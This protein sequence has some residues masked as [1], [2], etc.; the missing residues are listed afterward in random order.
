[1]KCS[2][3]AAFLLTADDGTLLYSVIPSQGCFVLYGHALHLAGELRWQLKMA[4]KHN[5]SRALILFVLLTHA[6][7]S[8]NTDP[9]CTTMRMTAQCTAVAK[10]S[11]TVKFH[12]PISNRFIERHSTVILIINQMKQKGQFWCKLCYFL[13]QFLRFFMIFWLKFLKG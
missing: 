9:N 12:S 8:K 10:N 7:S 11:R 6:F 3:F 13:A 2:R 4:K 5:T 1:L